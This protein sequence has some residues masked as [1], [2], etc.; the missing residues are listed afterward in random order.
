MGPLLF[1]IFVNDLFL[2]VN[3]VNIANCADDNTYDSF[4]TIEEVILSLQKSAK[5]IFQWFVDNQ[6]NGDTEKCYLIM[7]TNQPVD[8]Q[9]DS[10]L[11]VRR[12]CQKMLRVKTDYK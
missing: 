7:S 4:N 11:I 10:S 8:I 5:S 3:N 9:L 12:D 2:I 1:N 6:T